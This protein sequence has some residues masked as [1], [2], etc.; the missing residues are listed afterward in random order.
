MMLVELRIGARRYQEDRA[1]TIVTDGDRSAR[2]TFTARWRMAPTHD[3]P[4]PG[5][6]SR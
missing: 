2:Q 1:T 3:T 6:S 4:T 5:R